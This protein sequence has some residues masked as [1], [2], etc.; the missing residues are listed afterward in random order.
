MISNIIRWRKLE[1]IIETIKYLD[2][3][4]IKGCVRQ[5]LPYLKMCIERQDM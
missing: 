1:K 4:T 3:D 5:T 2:E